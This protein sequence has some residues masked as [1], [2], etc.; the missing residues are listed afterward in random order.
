MSSIQ[1]V[2]VIGKGF[3]GSAVLQQLVNYGFVVT[4]LSRNPEGLKD[5]PQGVRVATADY[6]SLGSLV[7]AFKDQYAVVSTVKNSAIPEQKIFIDA[8]IASGVKRFIPSDFGA[9]TTNTVNRTLPNHVRKIK[10]QHYLA[11]KANDDELEYTIISTG[12]FLES[13]L[14]GP[15]I[16]DLRNR[17]VQLRDHGE[18]PFSVSSIETVGKAVAAALKIPEATKNRILRVH[19]AVLSQKK[20]VTLAKKYTAGQAWIETTVDTKSTIQDLLDGVKKDGLDAT[21]GLSLLV[22]TVL[23]GSYGAKHEDVDNKLLGLSTLT[24]V[25][26]EEK[27]KAAVLKA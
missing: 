19:E 9:G 21:K 24:D 23:S 11:E 20:V 15:V 1:N 5:L 16:V 10:I 27:V 13:L 4:V 14:D 22:T 6:T 26:V 3:L 25:E 8:S 18:H 17:S 12:V 2:T 7:K